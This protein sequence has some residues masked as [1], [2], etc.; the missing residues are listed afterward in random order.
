MDETFFPYSEKG[1]RCL[2]W[3]AK[4]R[5]N[6]A[7]KQGRSK[8]DWVAVM[9]ARDRSKHTYEAVLCSVTSAELNRNLMGRI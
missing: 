8:E 9:T 4:K 7:K 5:G 2:S 1:S 6:K 3:P